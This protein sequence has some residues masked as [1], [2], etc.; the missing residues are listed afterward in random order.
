MVGH[1]TQRVA[2]P[3][4]CAFCQT[5]DL[6]SGSVQGAPNPPPR[7]SLSASSPL[8][9]PPTDLASKV[10][11]GQGPN[12]TTPRGSSGGGIASTL[13]RIGCNTIIC[14]GVKEGLRAACW[15]SLTILA[16][17]SLHF[18]FKSV[19]VETLFM[20]WLLPRSCMLWCT[21]RASDYH[22][23]IIFIPLLFLSTTPLAHV[24][25]YD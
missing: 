9:P 10:N 12:G 17:V 1:Q 5:D 7:T 15:A 4:R 23:I 22:I 19:R 11:G 16:T 25:H 8:T 21:R 6:D 2:E 20:W 3:L 24:L 18:R 14:L 13:V